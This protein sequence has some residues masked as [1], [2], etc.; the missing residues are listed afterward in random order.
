[1]PDVAARFICESTQ[2]R[3]VLGRG[4]APFSEAAHMEPLPEPKQGAARGTSAA[5]APWPLPRS[6][7][8]RSPANSCRLSCLVLALLLLPATALAQLPGGERFLRYDGTA[9]D[10]DDGNVRYIES[11]YV[12]LDGDAATDRY[13]LYRCTNGKAFA[14]KRVTT[15][16]A[17]PWLPSFELLDQRIQYRE[18]LKDVDNSL[19]VF[20]AAEGEDEKAPL[21]AP[22]DLVADA[23]FDRFVVDNW[24]KLTAG[25][26]V[27]FNFLVPS[28]LDYLSF[29]VRQVETTSIDG[30]KANVF[31]LALTG[32]LGLILSGIDVTYDAESQVLLR[33]SGLSNVRDEEGD[34]YVVRIE[35]PPADREIGNSPAAF[36]AA[37]E[38]PLV[39][40]CGA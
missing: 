36:D 5:A 26:T 33:F 15:R 21:D 38:E 12:K 31:R 2:R 37:S 1:M 8:S 30:R 14:R 11:H 13:V 40:T 39:G 10:L 23:G 32:L 27:R 29:K 20:Y 22:S 34:N 24:A 16:N 7:S 25:D 17:S 19:A 3:G 35:F 4:R 28:R 6:R 9:Y 18:G